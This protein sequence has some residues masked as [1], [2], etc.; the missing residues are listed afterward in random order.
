MAALSGKVVLVGGSYDLATVGDDTWE[1]DGTAWPLRTGSSPGPHQS[2]ALAT[3]GDKIV[4]VGGGF[5][6]WWQ[7]DGNTWTQIGAPGPSARMNPAMASLVGKVVLFG[8]SDGF[9]ELGD[10]WNW[11]GTAWVQ[12]GVYGA[13]TSGPAGRDRHAMAA[14]RRS[15]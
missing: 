14:R 15:Q 6:D 9:T 5:N 11:D 8:G 3:L 13:G 7:W 4:L 2:H 12:Y 1:W 10:T